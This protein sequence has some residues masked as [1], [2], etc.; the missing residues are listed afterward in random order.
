MLTYLTNKF[1]RIILRRK[2]EEPPT[3]KK[4][5]TKD[6]KVFGTRRDCN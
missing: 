1:Y 6:A 5:I 4:N 3:S 2:Y